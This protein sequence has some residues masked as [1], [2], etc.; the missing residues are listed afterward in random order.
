MCGSLLNF[1]SA[2]CNIIFGSDLIVYNA[3]QFSTTWHSSSPKPVKDIKN[4]L[5]IQI[6]PIKYW[7]CL[8]IRKTLISASL[9]GENGSSQ[10][11]R[12]S[13]I[14]EGKKP[15]TLF[16]GHS[17]PVYS[18]AF[19]PFGDFLLSSSSDSTSETSR[20]HYFYFC[21]VSFHS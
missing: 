15:Y 2:H 5:S 6:F 11:E 17:G 16:Q 10:G 12:M 14:D 13:T 4:N 21:S 20:H 19:S 1:F 7:W 3:L 8:L 9:Q 18:A